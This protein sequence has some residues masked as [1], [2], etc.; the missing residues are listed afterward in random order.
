MSRVDH[1]LAGLNGK[2]SEAAR[3]ARARN[4]SMHSPCTPSYRSIRAL[5]AAMGPD[6]TELRLAPQEAVGDPMEQKLGSWSFSGF[7][8]RLIPFVY[9]D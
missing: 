4:R 9:P 3:L 2:V 8:A 5:R 7:V 1:R 6:P